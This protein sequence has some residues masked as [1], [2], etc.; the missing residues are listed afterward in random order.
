[1]VVTGGAVEIKRR[2]GVP[3]KQRLG[4]RRSIDMSTCPDV[5][6]LTDGRIAIVGADETEHLKQKLPSDA[7]CADYERIVVIDRATWKSAQ[8][9]FNAD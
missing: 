1:M 5:F 9:D 4:S 2:L 3:P 7:G 8:R 6:E